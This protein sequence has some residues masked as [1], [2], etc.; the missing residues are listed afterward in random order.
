MLD[1]A[2]TEL[3]I[4]AVVAILVVGPR[5]LPR[6]LRTIGGFMG[7]MRRMAGDFQKQF[8]DAI[9]ETEL[10]D[11]KRGIDSVRSANPLNKIKDDLNPL[12]QAGDS[13]RKAVEDPGAPKPPPGKASGAGDAGK[14]AG[15]KDGAAAAKPSPSGKAGGAKAKPSAA[16]KP[17]ASSQAKPAAAS[18][19][20]AKQAKP[21]PGGG[22]K[23]AKAGSGRSG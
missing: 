14:A 5:E 7:Q 10:D 21:V 17:A 6:M 8:N 19:A 15:G 3:L 12:K 11:L 20:P 9:R 16:K 22:G 4:I 1:I 18:K 13:M 23:P 2:W